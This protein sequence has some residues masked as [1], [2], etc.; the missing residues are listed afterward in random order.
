MRKSTFVN[1]ILTIFII[2]NI[3]PVLPIDVK[4]SLTEREV[5]ETEAFDEETF[6]AILASDSCIPG[7]IHESAIGDIRK[8]Q[9]N[10][11]KDFVRRHLSNSK[12]KVVCYLF[13]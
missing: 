7:E 11:M 8:T 13:V 5:N 10:Q 3:D 9:D 2:Y 1:K 4:F 6:E 12:I